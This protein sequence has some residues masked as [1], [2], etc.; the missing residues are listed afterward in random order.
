MLTHLDSISGAPSR[1]VVLGSRGFVGRYT[2][3]GLQA[4]GVPV[5][6][7][8]STDIDLTDPASV[9]ALRARFRPEDAVVIVSGLTPDRG[10][11]IAT[12]MRNL[13]MVQHVCA[14]LAA[15]P[16]AHVVHVG[17][18]AVYHDDANPVRES[19]CAQ[20]SSF[21]GVM[22]MTRERM[23][24]ESMRASKTPLAL[25]RP[26]ILYGPGDTHNAYGPNRFVRTALVDGR[27]ALFGGG[28]EQRDH[29]FIED[30]AT[31][32]RLVL[33]R[34]SSGVLN[35]VTG[36]SHAFAE[37]AR[38]V[39]ELAGRPVAIEPSPRA[40][41]ITHRH[42]DVTARIQAFPD[43]QMTTLADGLRRSVEAARRG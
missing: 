13:Q 18:D 42:F 25:L 31:I 20:P 24:I 43:L 2:V 33:Q 37:V 34:R 15:S 14:A 10:R 35:L 32:I 22:H 23:L 29:V 39:A 21:H 1:A 8:A 12:L 17:S 38:T 27:I 4:A 7:I 6:A 19:S 11:D 36:T 5:E 40:N 26:S 3:A 41:P 9:E 28:E 30:V 16:V